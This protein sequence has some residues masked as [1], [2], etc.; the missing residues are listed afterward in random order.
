MISWFNTQ[1]NCNYPDYLFRV[2]WRHLAVTS[3]NWIYI[4]KKINFGSDYC[5][6]FTEINSVNSCTALPFHSLPLTNSCSFNTPPRFNKALLSRRQNSQF[7]CVIKRKHTRRKLPFCTY[8]KC[9]MANSEFSNVSLPNVPLRFVTHSTLPVYL[10][11]SLNSWI[12]QRRNKT[13]LHYK[14]RINE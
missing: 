2:T 13:V 14:T 6:W 9:S 11:K 1:K 8:S 5:M 3:C 7:L 4:C 10:T 12:D